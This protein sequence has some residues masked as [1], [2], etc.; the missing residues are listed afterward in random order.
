MLS[1]IIV[2]VLLG[3]F[4]IGLRRGFI[5][6]LIH[7]TGFFVAI[8]VAYLFY[9]QFANY[10]RLWIP[11]PQ[12]A[13]DDDG[14]LSILAETINLE[15]VYYNAIAFAILFFG[16]KI[17]MHIVGSMLDFVANLPI[18]RTINGWLG[19]GLCF[20]EAYLILFILLH[21][22]GIIPIEMIQN[23]IQSSLV[24]TMMIDNTPF[25]SELMNGLWVKS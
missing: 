10:I 21:V 22:G 16:T 7:L 19:G 13:N 3:S 20:L 17:I 25:L 1:V 23:S 9:K 18:L 15:N 5:L 11:Y 6:Q 2:L 14:V 12:M 8:T 24:A 4:F